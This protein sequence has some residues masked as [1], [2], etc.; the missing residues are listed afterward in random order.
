[1]WSVIPDPPI[2]CLRRGGKAERA[3]NCA[4]EW[5]KTG[6]DGKKKQEIRSERKQTGKPQMDAAQRTLISILLLVSTGVWDQINSQLLDILGNFN[7]VN[8]RR[9]WGSDYIKRWLSAV[10]VLEPMWEN[11]TGLKYYSSRAADDLVL[12]WHQRSTKHKCVYTQLSCSHSCGSKGRPCSSSDPISPPVHRL[13]TQTL[14][15]L[16]HCWSTAA[17]GDT[18][19]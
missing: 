10:E 3:H 9:S 19:I 12:V 18:K 14:R 17:S 7:I 15:R 4:W 5:L 11:G 2:S 16:C 8:Q 6:R 13:D 1:M